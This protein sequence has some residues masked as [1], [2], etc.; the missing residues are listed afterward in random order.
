MYVQGII[1]TDLHRDMHALPFPASFLYSIFLEY[2]RLATMSVDNGA[3]TQLYAATSPK[4]EGVT[5]RYFVTIAL[6]RTEKSNPHGRNVTLA[7]L[8]WEESERIVR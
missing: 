7:K 5:G 3:L 2:Y 4:M 8:L 1:V 6:D